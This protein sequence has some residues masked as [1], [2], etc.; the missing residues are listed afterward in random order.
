MGRN[1]RGV[2]DGTGP[3][4]SGTGRRQAAG[5]KC[6]YQEGDEWDYQSGKFRKRRRDD[7]QLDSRSD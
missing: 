3:Y 5:M 4:G 1:Q 7:G 6:P 2:R